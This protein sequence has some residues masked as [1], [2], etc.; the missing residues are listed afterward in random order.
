MRLRGAAKFHAA[1]LVADRAIA[2]QKNVIN[3]ARKAAKNPSV[4]FA[5]FFLS[6]FVFEG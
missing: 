5:A 1:I 3:A 4:Y 6:G 2:L